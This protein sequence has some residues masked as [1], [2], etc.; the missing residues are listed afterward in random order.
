MAISDLL[1]VVSARDAG[2]WT[3]RT[4]GSLS[5]LLAHIKHKI[6]ALDTHIRP[7]QRLPLS[8][9]PRRRVQSKTRLCDDCT[10]RGPPP[11]AT[12]PATM[13]SF[14]EADDLAADIRPRSSKTS[15]AAPVAT[16]H[17]AGA[18]HAPPLD[19]LETPDAIEVLVDLPGVAAEALRVVFKHGTLWSPARNCRPRTPAADGVGLPPRRAQLRALRARGAPGHGR[20]TRCA[21]AP[22]SPMGESCA[23]PLP[24]IDERRGGEIAVPVDAS[25]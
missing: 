21:R 6:L 17:H 9:P 1:Q 22:R 2:R 7:P 13:F 18:V 10:A 12:L 4:N 3:A 14:P 5:E 25:E 15:T 23:S 19:V 24:R 20:S 8:R 11:A 16:C